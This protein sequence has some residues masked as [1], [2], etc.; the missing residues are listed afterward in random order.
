[1]PDG[2]GPIQVPGI[3]HVGG[4]EFR[5]DFGPRMDYGPN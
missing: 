4:L 5:W 3:H 1:M 2:T